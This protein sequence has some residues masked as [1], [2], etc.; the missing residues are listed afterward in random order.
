MALEGVHDLKVSPSGSLGFTTG[1]GR[2]AF[3]RPIA[4]QDTDGRRRPVAATYLG[5]LNY[6]TTIAD[7]A[8]SAT[9]GDIYVTGVDSSAGGFPV[10]AGAFQ[11]A[12]SEASDAYIARLP[13]DLKSFTAAI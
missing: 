7:I 12:R 3:S 4:W 13:T 8:I 9:S 1:I 5:G 6:G 11:T 2:M 10:S